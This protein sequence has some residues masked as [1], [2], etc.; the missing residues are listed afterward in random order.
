MGHPDHL[1]AA[2]FMP[3][4]ELRKLSDLL[5]GRP[6]YLWVPSRDSLNRHR[7]G[8]YIVALRKKGIFV[9]EIARRLNLSERQVQRILAKKKATDGGTASTNRDERKTTAN[10]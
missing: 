3:E 6:A 9:L 2:D 4:E 1:N 5:G 7:R 8:D 10:A